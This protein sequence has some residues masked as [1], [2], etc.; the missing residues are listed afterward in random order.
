MWFQHPIKF[1]EKGQKWHTL[2]HRTEHRK[3]TGGIQF[4]RTGFHEAS[5]KS[6]ILDY[7]NTSEC[8]QLAVPRTIRK[9]NDS[10]AQIPAKGLT[11]VHGTKPSSTKSYAVLEN[12]SVFVR[13]KSKPIL[14]SVKAVFL[15]F[16]FTKKNFKTP[17]IF[18][19]ISI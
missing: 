17:G 16:P 9:L 10:V 15:Y 8:R 11:S 12:T 19:Q 18:D 14:A 1:Q 6:F 7:A 13:S 5:Q 2:G 4:L 3:D